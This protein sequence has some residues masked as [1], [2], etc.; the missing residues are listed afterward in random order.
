MKEKTYCYSFLDAC[1][2]IGGVGLEYIKKADL[3]VECIASQEDLE[4]FG[5]TFDDVLDRTQAGVNFL[6]RAKELCAMT[7]KV[8]WTNVAYTLN[9]T[10]L[11][12]GRFSFEFSE[13]LEDYIAG[14]RHSLVM[15]D[16]VARGPVEDFIS[17]LENS[18]E[19][20]GR[21]MVAHFEQNVQREM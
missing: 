5:V 12:D 1:V 6:R 2:L 16:N 14:L 17:A 10:M 20:A 8:K 13:C 18:D 9:I 21:R 7:Q 19:E 11:P 15:A 3:K 4:F